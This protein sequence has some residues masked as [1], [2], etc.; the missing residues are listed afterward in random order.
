MRHRASSTSS[1]RQRRY[2]PP[3]LTVTDSSLL[4]PFSYIQVWEFA[5]LGQSYAHALAGCI[6]AERAWH[7]DS[8]GTISSFSSGITQE[9]CS[10]DI[11]HLP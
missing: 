4:M 11:L 10:I 1:L 7:A 5:S 6:F 3:R 8:A 9:T 2:R